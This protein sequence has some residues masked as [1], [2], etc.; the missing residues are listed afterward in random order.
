MPN[1]G[2]CDGWRI[3]VMTRLPRCAP[4]AW[5][6]PTV[7]VVL[8]SPSGVGVMAVTSMYLPFGRFARRLRISSLTFAL[9]GPNNSNSFS[10]MPSSAAICRIGLSFPACAISISEGTGRRSLSLVGENRTFFPL[11]DKVVPTFL[12]TGFFR[13]TFFFDIDLLFVTIVSPLQ[14]NSV[15]RLF[16]EKNQLWSIWYANSSF[17]LTGC[18]ALCY[19]LKFPVFGNSLP[20]RVFA[21]C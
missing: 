16:D 12:L 6:S 13:R 11:V 4:S 7:V 1:V 21:S 10:R 5:L 20:S 17:K 15:C 8:P 14:R 9:Y 19:Y 18:A 2:P 3:T